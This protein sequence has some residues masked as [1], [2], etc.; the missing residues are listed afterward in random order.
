M[1]HYKYAAFSHRLTAWDLLL[2]WPC[3]PASQYDSMQARTVSVTM[4]PA[5]AIVMHFTK[6]SSYCLSCTR[7][8]MRIWCMRP[9]PVHSQ[10][11]DRALHT[12]QW[13]GQPAAIHGQRPVPGHHDW[14]AH[15]LGE[16]AHGRVIACLTSRIKR[17]VYDM[18]A[19]VLAL[20][21]WCCQMCL[22]WQADVRA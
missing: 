16:H 6:C 7:N 20:V 4:L 13:A 22:H 21:V 11:R 17:M 5:A 19:G 2:A 10:V 9:L 3:G 1:R 8:H 14:C 18:L 12:R 15:L